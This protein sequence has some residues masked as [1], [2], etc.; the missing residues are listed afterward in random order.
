MGCTRRKG[1][2]GHS[3]IMR[4]RGVIFRHLLRRAEPAQIH[5]QGRKGP[6]A[7]GRRMGKDMGAS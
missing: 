1:G 3:K 2:C 7:G 5:V 6:K 4:R